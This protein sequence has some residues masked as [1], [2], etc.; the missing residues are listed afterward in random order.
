MEAQ[1]LLPPQTVPQQ[2]IDPPPEAILGGLDQILPSECPSSGRPLDATRGKCLFKTC[3]K[4]RQVPG[5][6][7]PAMAR[8]GQ[9][10]WL[11]PALFAS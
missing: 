8:R 6:R 10:T 9:R 3:L 7:V 1:L 4:I 11:R 2:P 5:R